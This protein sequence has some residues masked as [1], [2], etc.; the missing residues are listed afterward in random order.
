MTH[1]A[2]GR[3]AARRNR[4]RK[5]ALRDAHGSA[6]TRARHAADGGACAGLLAGTASRR[7][8]RAVPVVA[9][10]RA[11]AFHEHMA[12]RGIWVRLFRAGPRGIR[13]GLPPDEQRVARLQ[14]IE[15]MDKEPR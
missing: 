6:H 13:I 15:R 4:S 14:R 5:A 7:P 1:S 3:S 2:H 12:R 8:A 11:G 10:T 9:G